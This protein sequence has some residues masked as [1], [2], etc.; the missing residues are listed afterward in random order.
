MEAARVAALRGHDVTL[1]DKASTLGGLVPIAAVVKERE[2]E[3][4]V[5][6]VALLRSIS[7]PRSVSREAGS[8]RRCDDDTKVQTGCG[9]PGNRRIS[10]CTGHTGNRQPEG[11]SQ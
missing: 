2:L 9:D 8:N 7:S 10:R 11:G 1:C 3:A 5:D 4:L 6:I